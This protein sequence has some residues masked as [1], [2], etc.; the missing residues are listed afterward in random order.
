MEKTSQFLSDAQLK[1]EVDKCLYCAEKPCKEACPSDCSPADFIMAVKVGEKSDFK[2]AA[3]L[4]MGNN[5]LG[6]VCGVV[7]PDKHCMKACARRTFDASVNIPAVQAA[8]IKKANEL[9][10]MPEFAVS[11]SNAKKVAVVGAGPAGFGAAAVLAQK[12]YK[13]DI[14]DAD[15][16][17]GGMCNLIPDSRLDKKTLKTDLDFITALGAVSVKYGHKVPDPAKLKGSYNAVLVT[18]GLDD[19]IRLKLPGEEAAVLWPDFLKKP[20]KYRLKGRRVA[21]IGGGAVAVDCAETAH[22]GGAAHVELFA[23]EKLGEMPLTAK[24]LAGILDCGIHVSGRTRVTQ[25]VAKDGKITG[26]Q[27]IKVALPKGKKF[28][29]RVIVDLP[30]TGQ[31]RKDFDFVIIAVGS[32]PTFK[33]DGVQGVFYAGDLANGPTTVV[34]AVAAGKN[35]A[36]TIDTFV[37][38]SKNQPFDKNVKSR[39]VLSGRKLEPVPLEADFFGRKILSPFLLSAA[40]PSD[41]YEQ[42]KK[43]Y[44]AGWPGGVMKTA[45]DNLSIH[46]PA[47]YMFAFTQ[48]TYANCDNVSGH[49][50]DRVCKEIHK[51]R[52]EFPDRLTMAS[53]G[54]PVTGNDESDRKGWQSNTKKLEDGGAMGIEYSL[55]CPQ[56]G[57]GTK[58]DIVSQDAELTARIIGWVMEPGDPE[59]PKLFKLTAAVTS[60]YP[61]ISA[62]KEVFAKYPGKKAGVTLANTFPTL[63]FRKG[64]KKTWEEGIVVGMSG[65]GVIPIS[66][67]TLANV[68]RLGVAVSG[69]GGPMDYKAAAHFL[70][71]GAKTVQFC[72]IV[73]KNGY[74]VIDD[75]HS[76]LSHL[77]E[78]RGI[79]SVNELIGAALPDPIKGFM[80]LTATKKISDVNAELCRHCGNCTRCPYMAVSLD[81]DLVPVTDASKCIGCSIC[82]QK[83]FSGALYMRERTSREM[84]LLSES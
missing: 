42:M 81:S 8:I 68:S 47:E 75:L 39:V 21:V 31:F 66:N 37:T 25:I 46:I 20:A 18:T 80:E 70:A 4:I 52:R 16:S 23:L 51:L 13:V 1:A 74:G 57:D 76:G 65:E 84:K 59:I 29:P 63:A 83:C 45:F 30:G 41:G 62:I 5:P 64:A 35:A 77:M 22:A 11:K 58:G 54:G 67:L 7:C 34:E 2:R 6:G 82:A 43:A 79:K 50:I 61:I 49:S 48:S 73:M 69:N 78:E 26:L 72:T 14:Y 36:L 19:P 12:G 60:I 55:S 3:A 17:A 53:T 33:T 10:V 27:T 28:H 9:G 24:E 40:P 71:L 56:G 44:E 38:G 32:R 15:T